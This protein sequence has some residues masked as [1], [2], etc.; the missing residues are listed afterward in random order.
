MW[1][2]RTSVDLLTLLSSEPTTGS[3]RP[4]TTTQFVLLRETSAKSQQR[5]LLSWS[6][7]RSANLAPLSTLLVRRSQ[8][9][10]PVTP[11]GTLRPSL[12]VNRR[13]NVDYVM[14]QWS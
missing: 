2:S 13:P 4:T 7:G 3:P 5:Q 12:S 9:E 10:E 6:Q 8:K 11:G 1:N 14:P